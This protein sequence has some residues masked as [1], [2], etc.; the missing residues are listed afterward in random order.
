MYPF[1]KIRGNIDARDSTDCRDH[2]DHKVVSLLRSV[3]CATY[4]LHRVY[5]VNNKSYYIYPVLGTCWLLQLAGMSVT[6]VNSGRKSRLLILYVIQNWAR[7]ILQR[8]SFLEVLS[9]LDVYWQRMMH[10]K[11]STSLSL[12]ESLICFFASHHTHKDL[13]FIIPSLLFD[14]VTIILLLSGLIRRSGRQF[15]PALF[16]LILRDGFLYF[17]AVFI[18]NLSW[19]ITGIELPVSPSPALSLGRNNH[20]S[21]N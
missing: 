4:M 14:T 3:E 2:A 19:S 18:T 11:F 8:S 1:C 9:L 10:C 5:A 7:T 21:I 15:M 16:K 20:F 12:V 13:L 17:F 6:L